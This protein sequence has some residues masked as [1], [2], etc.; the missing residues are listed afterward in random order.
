MQEV[1]AQAR[2]IRMSPRK[3]RR[4]VNTIRGKR[5]S[6]ALIQLKYLP[7]AAARVVEKV[8]R[9]AMANAKANYKLE[10]TD[11]VISKA[12]VD[13]GPTLKRWRAR[14]RG[15]AYSI[16]K[17]TSHITVFVAPEKGV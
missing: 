2:W 14:S 9:S 8:V 6:E 10:Q 16:A 15:R 11:L 13:G 4:I 12:F 1:K 17:R 5:P 7:H 3:L